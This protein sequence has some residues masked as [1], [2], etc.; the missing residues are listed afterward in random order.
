MPWWV[1]F[2]IPSDVPDSKLSCSTPASSLSEMRAQMGTIEE[3]CEPLPGFQE[4]EYK[5]KSCVPRSRFNT[6][7]Q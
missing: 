2:R 5:W 3:M 7:E 6:S 4:K 1:W